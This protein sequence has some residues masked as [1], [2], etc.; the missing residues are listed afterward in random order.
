MFDSILFS[1]PVSTQ[2]FY[3]FL[4]S[5]RAST[6]TASPTPTHKFIR[7]LSETGRLLRCYTQ[8]IDGLE[9]RVG[10]TTSLELGRG[11]K[12][13]FGAPEPEPADPSRGCEAVQLHG[14]LDVLR[15]T[16]CAAKVDYTPARIATLLN[17]TAPECPLCAE[18]SGSR[19]A[20]GKR[21]TKIGSLRPNIVLYGEEHP[22]A[23]S[24]GKLTTAD[25]RAAPEAMVILG[26]SLKV[27]GLK[28]IV[29]E[30]AKAV[31]TKGGIVVFVNQT[32]P[33]ESTWG[34]VIDFWCEMDCDAWVSDIR[35]HRP[36]ICERQTRLP[37]QR[38]RKTTAGSDKA[39]KARGGTKSAPSTPSSTGRNPLAVRS[40]NLTT[41]LAA[42]STQTP[43]GKRS[44]VI[45]PAA[46][47]SAAGAR[48][49]ALA[50][51]AQA[52]PS[53]RAKIS[54]ALTTPSTSSRHKQPLQEKDR[55][56]LDTPSKRQKFLV[57]A[58]QRMG[59]P[60][61]S[62]MV[63]S[64]RTFTVEV[65]P[66]PKKRLHQE[67][68]IY[69]DDKARQE[70]PKALMLSEAIVARQ[71]LQKDATIA[72]AVLAEGTVAEAEAGT[73]V[74][75]AEV[76]MPMPTPPVV[77]PEAMFPEMIVPTEILPAVA[78][79]VLDVQ[80]PTAPSISEPKTP[81]RRSTRIASTISIDAV[82]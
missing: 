43:G 34:D 31:H 28:R 27:H 2:L 5:L 32:A 42:L 76:E 19:A 4:A 37:V 25:L 9:S 17:G 74:V 8:N 51:A 29:R 63:L 70:E 53:R 7:A 33:A 75:E 24:V 35:A 71:Q 50:K 65:P 72:I 54:T 64:G 26:T 67:I 36:D 82:A 14:D 49:A 12:R 68:S 66:S 52:T 22:A 11:K 40:S 39:Q 57:P 30:F 56:V 10:L 3:T 21:A 79:K 44:R 46:G 59:T 6:V 81:S 45:K 78:P 1:D 48:K 62:P 41:D 80:I 77:V 69:R 47:P 61:G 20:S 60:P 15:C 55:S 38:V 18:S 58:S 73:A 16:L 13:K 23:D